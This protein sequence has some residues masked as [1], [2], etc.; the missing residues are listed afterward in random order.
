MDPTKLLE[1][2]HRQVED[3]FDQIEKAEGDER[4]PLIR[5]L[6]TALRAHM[7]LEEEVL[8]P[9]VTAVTGDDQVQEAETEHE[10]ARKMMADMIALAPDEPGFDGALEAFKAGIEHHVEEEEGEMFPQL[11]SEGA[12]VLAEIATPFMQKRVELG[13]P[14]DAAALAAASTKEELLEEAKNAGVE[15]TS[16]MTKEQLAEALAGVMA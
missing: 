8:Y 4:M 12:Q 14:M 13:L 1:A 3:L 10:L 9:R 16:S 7:Q 2:D 5:E 11:R 15:G 6:E